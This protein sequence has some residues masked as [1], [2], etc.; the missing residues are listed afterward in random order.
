M[1]VINMKGIVPLNKENVLV[2][3]L[4]DLEKPNIRK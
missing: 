2:G 1:E 4:V 3:E